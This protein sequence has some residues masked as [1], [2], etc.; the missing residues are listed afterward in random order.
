[1]LFDVPFAESIVIYVGLAVIFV[2]FVLF[3]ILFYQ[4]AIRPDGPKKPDS[5][6]P[7]GV[8]TKIGKILSAI[9]KAFHGPSSDKDEVKTPPGCLNV[10]VKSLLIVMLVGLGLGIIFFG[11][12]VQSLTSFEGEELVAEVFC[13]SV[14]EKAHTMEMILIEKHGP[15]A[16]R[17]QRFSLT[18]DRWLISGDILEWSSGV[19][20]LG[21]KTMYKLTRIG[22]Y[23]A[24]AQNDSEMNVNQYSLVPEEETPRWAWLYKNGYY[25]PFIETSH[26][27]N[28]TG[29]PEPGKKVGIYVTSMGFSTSPE[30]ENLG[31]E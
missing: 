4:V 21:L 6:K 29:Y 28:V 8:M 19:N 5:K 9:L 31:L 2:A 10:V 20:F 23:F 1:M 7:A 15:D 11:A 12:F 18:G 16:Q 30:R 24:A 26:S 14:D 22:G 25:F 3:A 17:P 13:Q 27:K